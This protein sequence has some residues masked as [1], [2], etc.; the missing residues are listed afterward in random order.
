MA[1]AVC[2][3]V[4]FQYMDGLTRKLIA[5]AVPLL[6]APIA[7]AL[8]RWFHWRNR[9]G[10]A[11]NMRAH[12]EGLAQGFGLDPV[13]VE[14]GILFPD[15]LHYLAGRSFTPL[16]TPPACSGFFACGEATQNGRL[17]L[18]RN[19]DFFGRGVWNANSAAIVMHPEHGQRFCWLGALGVPA[20]GQGFN[21]HGLVVSLHTKFTR[22]LC[23]RGEPLFKMVHDVLAGCTTVEEAIARITSTPRLCGLTLFVADT[24]A[25]TAAAVGFSARHVEVLR[26]ERG[27]LVRTNHYTT[28]EM[29]RLEVAPHPWRANSYGRFDRLTQLLDE[30]YG[31][32]TAGDVPSLLSDCVDPFEQRKRIAG[33]IVAGANNVQ[34]IVMSPDDDAVWL[35]HGDYPVCHAERFLGFR[36]SAL[37]DGDE[38]RYSID[39]LPGANHL[40][41]TERAALFEYEQASGVSPFL[42]C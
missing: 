5:H 36:I 1:A 8:K 30:R 21:E 37:L 42:A 17:L 32:L 6:A 11:G 18:G 22:D 2:G 20:S 14:R 7:G 12:L 38:D 25:R 28:V 33:S 29:K 15:L 31:T 10:L 40:D 16:A 27:I 41:A 23:T 9:N 13:R 3:D 4:V 34:S 24:K 19:F 39:D 26:P 35:A